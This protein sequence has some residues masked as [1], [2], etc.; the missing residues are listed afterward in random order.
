MGENSRLLISGTTGFVGSRL[1]EV[2]SGSGRP[3]RAIVRETASY[4]SVCVDDIG[5][6]NDWTEALGDVDTVVHLAGMVQAVNSPSRS[7]LAELRRVNVHGT[8]NL[9]RQAAE[10][11]VRRFIFVSSI[12]VNGE[13][14]LPGKPF[15]I[16]DEPAPQDAYAISKSEAETGLRQLAENSKLEVVI[17]RPPLV[18]GPGVKGN[19]LSLIRLVKA[20]VPLPLGAIDNRRTMVALDNLVDLIITCISHPA[21]ANQTF[22]V[23]DDEDISTPDLLCRLAEAMGKKA[24][25]ISLPEW[26]LKLGASLFRKQNLLHRL[27]SNLQL[28]TSK[29]RSLLAWQPRIS[30]D[31]GIRK[32]VE[33]MLP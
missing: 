24:R 12:K 20:G 16:D 3:V 32:T 17:I 18:Y 29:T 30:V 25:L 15:T 28:D 7:L 5:P 31:E 14:T 13:F 4:D 22:L 9:A 33:S 27:C 21:A 19:F 11:G 26:S 6:D 1:L 8:L 2:V 10:A 23:G